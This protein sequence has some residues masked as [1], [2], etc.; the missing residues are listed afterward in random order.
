MVDET[1]QD[2]G[3]GAGSVG[4]K[5]PGPSFVSDVTNLV[6]RETRGLRADVGRVVDRVETAVSSAASAGVAMVEA[7]VARLVGVDPIDIVKD[8][9]RVHSLIAELET[10]ASADLDNAKAAVEGAIVSIARHIAGVAVANG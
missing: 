7:E 10:N 9:G 6:R 5:E 8:L 4:T 1:S 3:E 2:A